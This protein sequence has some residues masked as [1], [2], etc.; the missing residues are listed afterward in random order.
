MKRTLIGLIA[1]TLWLGAWDFPSS[2]RQIL[3]VVS[4]GW[5]APSAKLYRL[6]KRGKAWHRVGSA[7]AVKVG[8]NGMGWGRGVYTAAHPSEPR[9]REGDKRAPAGV[10]RLPFFF[11]E[12]PGRFDY[13]YRRMSERHRCVDDRRSRNY[14]RIIDGAR[15]PRDY[16]S[17]EKMK[18]ASGLYRYGIFVAHN[19][20][21][22]PGAGSCIF[23]HI[24]KRNGAPTVGCTAMHESDLL[25]VMHWLDPAKHPLLIQAPRQAIDRLLPDNVQLT[26]TR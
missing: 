8:R 23:L 19:P 18:F 26:K 3:V 12:G 10:F 9:K 11:G 25:R 2:T 17:A 1:A 6:E 24:E 16:R 22:V 20:H 7:I 5:N 21:N 4:K 14:N 15:A 13:P